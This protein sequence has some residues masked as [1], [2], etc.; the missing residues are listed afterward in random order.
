MR[1]A[2]RDR[3]VLPL[4]IPLGALVIIAIP[5]IGFS[6]I[7]LSLS[8]HAATVTAF[9]VVVAI[10]LLGIRFSSLPRIRAATLV[11]MLGGVAGVAMVA[12]GIALASIGSGEEAPAGPPPG[13]PATVIAVTAPVG[14]ATKGFAETKLTSP[15]GAAEVKFD[16]QDSGTPHNVQVFTDKDYTTSVGQVIEPFPG[17]AIKT[18]SI[19]ELKPDT[20]YYFRCDVHPTTMEGTIEVAAGGA[21]GGGE[22][23]GQGGGE[24]S[25]QPPA[26]GEK[27]SPGGSEPSGASASGSAQPP[28]GGGAPSGPVDVTAQNLAFDKTTIALPA[29]GQDTI[30]FTNDDAG[31][32]HNIVIFSADPSTDASAKTLFT[33]D[34]VTGP[35]STDYTFKAPPPGQYFFRCEFH[36][37]TMKGTV[38]VG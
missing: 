3:L 23:P 37:D 12:G 14:A 9:V 34:P 36:P 25:G 24:P 18:F 8:A 38:T 27:P 10:M 15:P 17:P 32:P 28:A 26:G 33:G 11:G 16:N 19:G 6:R 30:H 5:V 35:G 4:L 2:T 13:P 7:L 1:K 22:K 29:S 20:A 21:P 31:V